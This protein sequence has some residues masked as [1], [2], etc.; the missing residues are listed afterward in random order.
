MSETPLLLYSREFFLSEFAS[1][2][3]AVFLVGVFPDVKDVESADTG[4][5]SKVR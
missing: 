5:D 1:M 2:N 3:Y 4:V